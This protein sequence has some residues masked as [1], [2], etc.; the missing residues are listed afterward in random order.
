MHEMVWFEFV[1]PDPESF[2]QFHGALSGWTFERDFEESDLVYDYWIV[3]H[4]GRAVG[5]LQQQTDASGST[6]ATTRVYFEVDDLEDWLG[7]AVTL[8]GVVERARTDLGPADRWFAT[9]RDPSGVSV[10]LW[11]NSPARG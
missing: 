7:R 2:M 4:G 8:G 11:T 1:T 5:G 3:R 6:R 9:F 10:G